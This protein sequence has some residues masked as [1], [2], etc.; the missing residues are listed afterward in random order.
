MM[1]DDAPWAVRMAT[2]RSLNAVEARF[3]EISA[4]I[5]RD[6]TERVRERRQYGMMARDEIG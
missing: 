5:Q 4:V 6:C 2:R 1:A 3:G